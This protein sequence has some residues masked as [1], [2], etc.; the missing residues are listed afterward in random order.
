M[1]ISPALC[2]RRSCPQAPEQLPTT[3]FT[4]PV[5][6]CTLLCHRERLLI[7][8]RDQIFLDETFDPAVF[9]LNFAKSLAMVLAR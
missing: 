1:P 2:L 4:N 5:S 7:L 9:S 6:G 8:L 3:L